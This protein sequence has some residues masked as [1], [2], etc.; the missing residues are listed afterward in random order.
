M[1]ESYHSFFGRN[2]V[3]RIRALP[4]GTGEREEA[5][6]DEYCQSLRE[7]CHFKYVS[8][9]VILD[10][11]KERVRYYFVFATN[12]LHGIQVFKD[13]ESQ[14][15]EAPGR[16]AAR[17]KAQEASTIRVAIR[18]SR[19]EILQG[20]YSAEALSFSLTRKNCKC[21]PKQPQRHSVLR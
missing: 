19:S 7:I 15:A 17:N 8:Q 20:S 3:D 16:I 2:V 1:E 12:S 4:K 14:A 13:A 18:R 5:A 21:D 9:A 11:S 10:A 6:V